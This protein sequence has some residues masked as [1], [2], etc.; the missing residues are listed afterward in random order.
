V[1]SWGHPAHWWLSLPWGNIATG[2]SGLLDDLDSQQRAAA[3]AATGP[4]CIMAGAGSGKT[5]TV[6]CRL[7]YGILTKE[8]EASRALAI[9]HSKKAAAELAERLHRS[10]AGGVDARTFHA[11]GLRVAGQFLGSDR[12]ARSVAERAGR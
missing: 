10:G 4:V 11:A 2:M 6:T 7:A 8:V 3:R 1:S 5:R 12:T 9:T